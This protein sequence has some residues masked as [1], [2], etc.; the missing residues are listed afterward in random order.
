MAL[1][2]IQQTY[3]Q[4]L[5]LAEQS[6][7]RV[8]LRDRNLTFMASAQQNQMAIMQSESSKLVNDDKSE[9]DRL[10]VDAE[11]D[12]AY[13]R[14]RFNL[15]LSAIVLL[16]LTFS[17]F[18]LRSLSTT[19]RK[20]AKNLTTNSSRVAAVAKD[21]SEGSNEQTRLLSE[22]SES[23]RVMNELSAKSAESARKTNHISV[24]SDDTAKK[25]KQSVVQVIEAISQIEQSNNKVKA[26]VEM[27]NRQFSEMIG[28]IR[29]IAEKTR[30]I[31]DIAVQT[32][33]LSFNA[34]LEAVRAGE[35]GKGFAVVAEEVRSLTQITGNAAQEIGQMIQSSLAKVE[36]IVADT[37]KKVEALTSEGTHCIEQGTEVAAECSKVLDQIVEYVSSVNQMSESIATMSDE[38]KTRIS[39]ILQ[40]VQQVEQRNRH[41]ANS[42]LQ[43]REVG[44]ELASDAHSLYAL[45]TSLIVKREKISEATVSREEE[46]PVSFV[47]KMSAKISGKIGGKL[48][49]TS[50]G[51][52]GKVLPFPKLKQSQP[53]LTQD[54]QVDDERGSA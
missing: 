10:A 20:V 35:N 30:I 22:T 27:G 48:F 42:A 8:G 4:W 41:N 29:E 40:S 38:Q 23:V 17:F 39:S 12:A 44:D 9:L 45:V 36:T 37:G 46:A 50:S 28:V 5:G 47:E 52:L 14:Y 19:I 49:G 11:N 34:S 1:N 26:Q 18:T 43:A 33:L 25:G 6:A 15:L 53:E 54:D 32:R 16:G 3:R 2:R 13:N 24:L 31:N 51:V 7:K 21:L